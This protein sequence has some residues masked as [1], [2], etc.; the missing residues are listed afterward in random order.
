MRYRLL[1]LDLDDTVLGP[2]RKVGRRAREVIR[3]VQCRDAVVVLATGRPYSSARLFAG[4]LGIHGPVIANS[5][6][7]V[8][9]SSGSVLRELT[10]D[11]ALCGEILDFAAGH[12]LAA[13][14]YTPESMHCNIPHS[15]S[16][17]YSRILEVPIEVDGD[18]GASLGSLEL[19]ITAMGIRVDPDRAAGIESVFRRW[20]GEGAWVLRSIPTLIEILPPGAS[21]G[22]ALRYVAR[23]L[24]IPIDQCVAVGDSIGD[25]DMLEAAG[26]GVLVANAER[27]LHEE[28][29]L[30]TCGSYIEGVA[31]VVER[32]FAP[33]QDAAGC[34]GR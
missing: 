15:A 22:E 34:P 6:S 25:M 16:E 23:H 7:V 8:R 10:L 24:G 3:A 32:Y 1:A 14:V 2:D 17:R 21:K 31:E 33:G 9:D 4:R 26:R 18:L 12:G 30:V 28:A 27:Q 5:G 11:P 19:P 13:Y 29:D 20:V